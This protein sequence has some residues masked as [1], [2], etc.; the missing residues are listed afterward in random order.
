MLLC[1]WSAARCEFWQLL[2]E[3]GRVGRDS[4]V[5]YRRSGGHSGGDVMVVSEDLLTD[6]LERA[7]ACA[8]SHA[9]GLKLVAE[10][11]LTP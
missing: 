9:A 7:M 10:G 5:W 8:L 4:G 2:G 11:D 3:I 1:L 6:C